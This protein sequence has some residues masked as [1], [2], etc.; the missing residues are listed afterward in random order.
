MGCGCST[1]WT[2]LLLEDRA[3]VEGASNLVNGKE[4]EKKEKHID[5]VT[6]DAPQSSHEWLNAFMSAMSP[7]D[8][9]SP[10]WLKHQSLKYMSV[11]MI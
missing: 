10:E 2:R 11:K 9:F 7:P 4:K 3:Q 6:V 5:R 1:T 8:T